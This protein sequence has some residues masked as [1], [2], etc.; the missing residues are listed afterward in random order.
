MSR[1]KLAV[2]VAVRDGNAANVSIR[3]AGEVGNFWER[4]AYLV[5]AGHIDRRLVH[6]YLG[7]SARSWVG[8]LTPSTHLWREREEEPR[9]QEHFEWLVGLM[10]EM[11][12]KAGSTLTYDEA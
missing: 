10:A 3:A 8:W 5:R 7:N 12:R 9:L 2:L 4:T 6:E 11:D 1:S